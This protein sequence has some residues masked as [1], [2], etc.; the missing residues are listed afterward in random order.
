MSDLELREFRAEMKEAFEKTDK[1]LQDVEKFMHGWV[2]VSKLLT[3]LCSVV[4]IVGG[5]IALL[6]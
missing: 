4:A 6:R 2:G 5:A 3:I 1:R